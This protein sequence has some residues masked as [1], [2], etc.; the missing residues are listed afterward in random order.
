MYGRRGKKHPRFGGTPAPK[1]PLARVWAARTRPH[2]TRLWQLLEL[3]NLTGE[4]REMT[5]HILK[6]EVLPICVTRDE[7]HKMK[8]WST[9]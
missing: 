2:T 7:T 5:Y 1:P 9:S 6:E 8:A 4:R 3:D